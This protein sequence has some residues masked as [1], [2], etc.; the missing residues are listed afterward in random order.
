M[1]SRMR[2]VFF[3]L[4]NWVESDLDNLQK[5]PYVYLLAAAEVGESGTPHLQGYAELSK[6]CSLSTLTDLLA[7]R[8]H[9]ETAI[10]KDMSVIYC[11][12]GAQSK[13]E[14]KQ[15]GCNG[16]SYGKDL[17]IALEKGE[18]KSPGT[19][20]DIHEVAEQ[21]LCGKRAADIATDH[22]IV[23]IK[24]SKGISAM[25]S[26]LDKPRDK[27]APLDVVVHYGPTGTGKTWKAMADHPT[28]FKYSV[29]MAAW[30]DG[31][32][33]Q[34]VAVFD[35]FRG[36]LPFA[37]LLQLLDVYAVKVQVKGGFR[38][39][40]P[41]KIIITSPEHPALWYPKLE[42]REGK[43]KQLKR[44][45]HAIY[46]FPNPYVAGEAVRVT[47]HTALDWAEAANGTSDTGEHSMQFD[48][49]F[50]P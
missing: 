25:I 7:K 14:W 18:R 35:E 13:A 41:E 39:W 24:Y 29:A 42:A 6:P 31:Y 34:Q 4:N 10:D 3:T 16:P 32:E 33:G 40:K 20:N 37:Q 21:V 50:Q 2:N 38:E 12:K 15:L 19:R 23:F 8:A 17:V 48:T 26:A 1:P 9:I 28:A 5:L 22:P 43:L 44:R 46:Y 11:K 30:F 36:Q 45:I 49:G 27:S 47:D